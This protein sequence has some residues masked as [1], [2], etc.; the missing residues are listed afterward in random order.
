VCTSTWHPL[1]GGSLWMFSGTR[2]SGVGGWKKLNS[3]LAVS[4]RPK[5]YPLAPSVGK[6][7]LASALLLTTPG[8]PLRAP[9][10]WNFF[11]VLRDKRGRWEASGGWWRLECLRKVPLKWVYTV[12]E[13]GRPSAGG[14]P[15]QGAWR[16]GNL[17]RTF[18]FTPIVIF[19][20]GVCKEM[21]SFCK[22]T[23]LRG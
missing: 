14:S 17:V 11:D 4:W 16:I 5:Q 21:G 22:W 19:A 6:W 8:P 2:A 1:Y 18:F 23:P 9:L 10:P 13:K 12:Q 15:E 3:T 20:V 7:T